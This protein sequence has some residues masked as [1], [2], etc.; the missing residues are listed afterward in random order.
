MSD[1]VICKHTSLFRQWCRRMV[2]MNARGLRPQLDSFSAG[3]SANPT[4]HPPK[5]GELARNNLASTCLSDPGPYHLDSCQK[6]QP[7]LTNRLGCLRVYVLACMLACL[8]ACM[9]AC[10]LIC[11]LACLFYR[12]MQK[13]TGFTFSQQS[14]DF[15]S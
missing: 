15:S 9:L 1:S 14:Q 11:L 7:W 3:C 12:H 10:L 6:P 5:I 8:L 13:A 4:L 2:K